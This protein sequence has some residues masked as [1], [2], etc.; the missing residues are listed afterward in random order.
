LAL[1]RIIVRSGILDGSDMDS[2]LVMSAI[3]WAIIT[4]AILAVV[5]GFVTAFLMKN[6]E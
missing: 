4:P 2:G 3:F 5:A 6:K 1:G